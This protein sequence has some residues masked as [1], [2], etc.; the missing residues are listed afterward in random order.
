MGRIGHRNLNNALNRMY[1]DY[2]RSS[3]HSGGNYPIE[4]KKKTIIDE[5]AEAKKKTAKKLCAYDMQMH[6]SDGCKFVP[7]TDRD[8]VEKMFFSDMDV[9]Q[10]EGKDKK[11]R[12]NIC[13]IIGPDGTTEVC[14]ASEY[15]YEQLEDFEKDRIAEICAIVEQ[16]IVE[17][18][19]EISGMKRFENDNKWYKKLI[20]TLSGKKPNMP[21]HKKMKAFMETLPDEL[22]RVKTSDVLEGVESQETEK[23]LG[24]SLKERVVPETEIKYDEVVGNEKKSQAI[25]EID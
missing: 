23:T 10:D 15:Y 25:E 20:D 19:E 1:S 11:W 14:L 4:Q 18:E 9:P 13:G 3:R 21:I 22:K 24:D 12:S 16:G 6:V 17:Q 7:Y 5:V 2:E 8:G